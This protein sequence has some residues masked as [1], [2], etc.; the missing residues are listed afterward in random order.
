M[1]YLRLADASRCLRFNRERRVNL[2][3]FRSH[4]HCLAQTGLCIRLRS[5]CQL[6]RV[7]AFFLKQALVVSESIGQDLIVG[8]S[9]SLSSWWWRLKDAVGFMTDTGAAWILPVALD[10]SLS[11]ADTGEGRFVAVRHYQGGGGRCRRHD[12]S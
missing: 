9:T 12:S 5:I 2:G 1:D 3:V 6:A 11:A 4:S 8:K 7:H 10:F